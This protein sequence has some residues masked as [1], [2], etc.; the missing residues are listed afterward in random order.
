MGPSLLTRREIMSNRVPILLAL[1]IAVVSG[2]VAR[3]DDPRASGVLPPLPMDDEPLKDGKPVGPPDAAL[4]PPVED[5]A[6]V[7][8]AETPEEEDDPEPDWVWAPEP[9]LAA[10]MDDLLGRPDLTGATV[11]IFAVEYPTGRILYQ[12]HQDASLKPAS[13]IK[14]LTA[15]AFLEEFGGDHRFT[16][17]LRT[18]GA[19]LWLVGGGDPGLGAS[20]LKTLAVRAKESG[21]TKVQKVFVDA[22]LFDEEDLPPHYDTKKTDAWYRP[23]VGAAAVEDGGMR[24][25]IS[26]GNRVGGGVLVEVS[27]ATDYFIVDNTA[28]TT[29]DDRG[30]LEVRVR[31][32]RGRAGVYVRGSLPQSSEGVT[33]RRRVPDPNL[34][35]GWLLIREMKSA[36]IM[37]E[38]RAP[39]MRAAPADSTSVH[40]LRSDRVQSDVIRMIKRSNN[41]V[42]EQLTKNLGQSCTPRGWDCSLERMRR[43][44][45]RIGLRSE[46]F[47]LENGSGLYDANRLSP[48]QIVRFFIEA[49]NRARVAPVLQRALAVAGEEGTLYRRL[50]KVKGRV[51]GKTG[52]LDGVSC[53]AGRASPK[54][55]QE[56]WFAI[57]INDAKAPARALRSIQDKMIMAMMGEW[58]PHRASRRGASAPAPPT[59]AR[60]GGLISAIRRG[61]PQALFKP[62]DGAL[63]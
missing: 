54:H 8:T 2:S 25:I 60:N 23:D 24:V 62:H 10:A 1:L 28:T 59:N 40:A 21:I 42:A 38:E 43:L 16:T 53:I 34:L 57:L 39:A 12:H 20:D 31:A 47:R 3:A 35:A 63:P 27:P 26:P 58:Q 22:T 32:S 29:E 44:V 11:G 48:R 5:P 61:E 49:A 55:G 46:R 56:I 50:H 30:D 45:R 52:T 15:A 33:V 17:T 13:V 4:D 14:V 19:S 36:G 18:D 41:F 6:A 9:A 51:H 37:V 7:T